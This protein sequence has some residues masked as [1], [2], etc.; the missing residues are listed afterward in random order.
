M[1]KFNSK[2]LKPLILFTF[3][4]YAFSIPLVT[5]SIISSLE[6]QYSPPKNPSA[7]VIIMLG[8]GATLDTPN[9]DFKGHLS[10]YSS[11]RL[12]TVL[13]LYKKLKV[14]IIISGG[15]VF[16]SSGTESK[17]AENILLSIGI[18]KSAIITD[19]RSINT[20][21]N[22]KYTSEL[23]ERYGFKKPI[24]VTS[25]FH[26]PRALLQFKKFKVKVV[27]YPTD[28]QTDIRKSFEVNDLIPSGDSLSKL[29]LGIKE[30]IGIF[31][32]KV[33]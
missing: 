16:K 12:L 22:A 28:Y 6:R 32:S 25:A 31:A 27:P 33:Y 5:D 30:Y 23:L 14:P 26:M 15:K 8:G 9:L 20:T 24:L 2:F 10:G 13:Q 11:N 7:D 19:D 17:I 4:F 18:P 29:S 1:H 3:I 21:E